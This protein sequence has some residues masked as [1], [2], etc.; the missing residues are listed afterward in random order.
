MLH[1]FLELLNLNS[2]EIDDALRE[3]FYHFSVS[4]SQQIFRIIEGFSKLYST[5]K[6]PNPDELF[7]F[8]YFILMLQTE[9]HSP[10]I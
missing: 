2:L 9:L 10:A 5:S 8:A 3:V 1:H 7:A 4:E 6:L